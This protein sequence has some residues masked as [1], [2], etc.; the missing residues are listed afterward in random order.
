M[1][2]GGKSKTVSDLIVNPSLSLELSIEEFE[3]WVIEPAGQSTRRATL[4][5]GGLLSGI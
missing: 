3:L 1:T 4:K 5:T 2:K